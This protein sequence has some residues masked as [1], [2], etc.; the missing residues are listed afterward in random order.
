MNV[1]EIRNIRIDD[2]GDFFL[3]LTQRDAD[4]AR[5]QTALQEIPST[6]RVGYTLIELLDEYI[7][8]GVKP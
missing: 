8:R 7:E 6:G 3:E 1:L 5:V 4:I 2:L